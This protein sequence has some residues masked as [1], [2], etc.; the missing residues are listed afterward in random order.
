MDAGLTC[1]LV[2]VTAVDACSA[3]R[4]AQSDAW[5]EGQDLWD[6]FG[7]PFDYVV[8]CVFEGKPVLW[9]PEVAP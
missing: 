9:A 6:C 4:T 3:Q 7:D 2:H 5:A 1:A 8:L